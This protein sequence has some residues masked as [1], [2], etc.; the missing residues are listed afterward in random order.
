[1]SSRRSVVQARMGGRGSEE[2]ESLERLGQFSQLGSLADRVLLTLRRIRDQAANGDVGTLGDSR[3]DSVLA[4]AESLF[5]ILVK[6]Q[7]EDFDVTRRPAMSTPTLKL[8]RASGPRA[9]A[10]ETESGE[11]EQVR[12]WLENLR[13]DIAEVRAGLR[14]P[15]KIDRLSSVFD[16]LAEM[17]LASATSITRRD[18]TSERWNKTQRL[19]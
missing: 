12:E 2:R 7:S 8:L 3:S 17:T 18:R 5:A 10:G 13:D 14:D 11:P 1:M 4:D 19:S 16:A 9:L 6:S 15:E